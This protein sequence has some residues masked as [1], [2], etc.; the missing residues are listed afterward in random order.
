MSTDSARVR[1]T[2]HRSWLILL[3]G[4]GLVG[5]V[6]VAQDA[7]TRYLSAS[8]E[9]RSRV[10]ERDS[11]YSID[12][13]NRVAR[14]ALQIQLLVN[15]HINETDLAIMA[16]I[17]KEINALFLDIDERSRVY[18]S[19]IEFPDEAAEWA[20]ARAS[21]ARLRKTVGATLD[22]SRQNHNIDA[23]ALWTSSRTESADLGPTL[24]RVVALNRKSAMTA[25]AEIDAAQR[26]TRE[27]NDVIRFLGLLGVGLLAVWVIRRV[28]GYEQQLEESAE[29]LAIQNHDLDAF[30]G[31]VAHDLKNALGPLLIFPA[32][33]RRD[34]TDPQRVRELAHSTERSTRR[35]SQVIDSLLAFARAS[36]AVDPDAAAPVRA[37]IESV[38]DETTQVASR[39]GA[40]VEVAAI[41][42]LLVRCEP[43]LLHVV[44]A[45]VVGN[46]V[47][48]L[49]G[50]PVRRVL[51]RVNREDDT[52]R[53]EIADTGPGIPKDQLQKIFEPFYRVEAGRG[54]GS[55]I[56]L[57]TVRR[58]LDA[59]S[60]R[61]EV[62]SEVDQGTRFVVW[63]PLVN[64]QTVLRDA[65][66]VDVPWRD[67][68]D[69]PRTRHV[70]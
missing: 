15:D 65:P 53:L 29:L 33:L 13:V 17:E 27:V 56:G 48:Y 1:R 10:L 31:R 50:R 2:R 8:N 47:K 36:H 43:G 61:V 37:A 5:S 63:L 42:D 40:T 25:T 60:G 52:C 3:I 34:A 39:L 26:R 46:A 30:A 12:E 14:D 58:I 32:L 24:E 57:A 21:L 45:N 59:R 69:A 49:S 11:F 70:H 67:P 18:E 19:L 20:K 16:G 41:P 66:R 68:G 64:S 35:T 28:L 7:I 51:I 22:L 55:G 44:L 9:Q 38:L 54:A 6:F 62:E 23:R 4:F